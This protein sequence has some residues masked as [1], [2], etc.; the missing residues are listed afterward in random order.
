MANASTRFWDICSV[1]GSRRRND[2]YGLFDSS[3][4]GCLADGIGSFPMGDALARYA[5]H[6]ALDAMKSGLDA[7]GSLMR[8][9]QQVADFVNVA[10]SPGSGAALT[11]L[12][13]TNAGLELSWLG[14]VACFLLRKGSAHIESLAEPHRMGSR[15]TRYVGQTMCEPSKTKLSVRHGDKIVLCTDGVWDELTQSDIQRALDESETPREACARLVLD[16]QANDNATA[17]AHFI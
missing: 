14:D 3:V 7:E 6:I 1:A 5:C 2:D 17:L 13:K 8:A 9:H 11:V 4:G 10:D 12:K 16:R 15:L